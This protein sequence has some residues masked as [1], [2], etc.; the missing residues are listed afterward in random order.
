MSLEAG[1]VGFL[2]AV[3]P[4]LTVYPKQLP[5]NPSLPASTYFIVDTQPEHSHSGPVD[6]VERRVQI[7]AYARDHASLLE[8]AGALRGALDGYVGDWPGV[9]I[10]H[11]LLD[12]DFDADPQELATRLWRRVQDYLVLSTEL[13]GS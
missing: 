12:N 1:L 9:R 2:A 3:L 10:G 11:C 6:P 4:G 7:D 13:A 8:L 5:A